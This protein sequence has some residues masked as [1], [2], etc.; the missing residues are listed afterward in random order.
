MLPL[1]HLCPTV[2]LV[3]RTETSCKA[4]VEGNRVIYVFALHRDDQVRVCPPYNMLCQQPHFVSY[5]NS[6]AFLNCS[7]VCPM[8]IPAGPSASRTRAA[9]SYQ[10]LGQGQLDCARNWCPSHSPPGASRA[11]ALSFPAFHVPVLAPSY[12]DAPANGCARSLIVCMPCVNDTVG[13]ANA[14]DHARHHGSAPLAQ[15]GDHARA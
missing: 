7:V 15:H 6:Q 12:S 2:P 11:L 4:I 9:A 14:N 3:T 1:G 13:G 8:A 10:G 5:D